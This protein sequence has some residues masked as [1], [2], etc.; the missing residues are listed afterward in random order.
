[1]LPVVLLAAVLQITGMDAR[2]EQKSGLVYIGTYTSG[3]SKGIYR[4]HFD[5]E[6]GKLSAP[7]LAIE[8][9]NPSFLAVHPNGKFLY[10]VGELDNFAGQKAGAVSAFSIEAG[11]GKLTLLNQQAS[12]GTGPCHL[13]VDKTGKCVVVAN[14]GS[15]SIAA[16]PVDE[17]GKL[18]KA[19]AIIQHRGSSVN[20]QRQSG[21][22]AHCA[23]IDPGNRFAL[24]CDLGLDKVFVYELDPG[25]ASLVPNEPLSAS[26]APGAGPRH[27]A[28]HPN[29]GTCFVVNEMG[30]S[31]TVFAYQPNR[32]SL[33][34]L[35]SASTL[36]KDFKGESTCAEIQVHPSGRFVYASNRGH[37][38]IAV[39]AL[40]G[41]SKELS[42]IE[43]QLTQGKTPRHFTLDPSGKWLL[44]ENQDSNDIVVFS[45]DEKSGKL[46]PTGQ[47]VELGA[48]VCLI[49]RD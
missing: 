27:V 2:A 45:V 8:T 37:N 34:E 17:E 33:K 22:H 3:K 38:S 49:F 39:F 19:G 21:P 42:L 32:G 18:G 20:P 9:K 26:V 5:A 44:A 35:S 12:G 47:R 13:A 16:L 23:V 4:A 24:T 40:A 48:P 31:V 11:T 7:E 10:A 30:S 1:M 15:G 46:T 28:F 36:P 29:G 43:N 14:Y 41:D 6:S 25:R